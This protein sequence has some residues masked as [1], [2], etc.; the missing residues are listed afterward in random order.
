MTDIASTLPPKLA[1]LY[2]AMPKDQDVMI[3]A[4]FDT[5]MGE[6]GA[7]T[8]NIRCGQ[9]QYLGPYLTKLNR[10]IAKHGQAVKPGRL[11]GSYRLVSL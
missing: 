10:R 5:L 8:R 7:E 2:G 3:P 9:Q 4:L 11:R 1:L 6:F